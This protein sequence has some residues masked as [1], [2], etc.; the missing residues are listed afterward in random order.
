MFVWFGVQTLDTFRE[1]LSSERPEGCSFM[2]L[3]NSFKFVDSWS[4]ILLFRT[5]HFWNSTTQLI[6]YTL[7]NALNC[8]GLILTISS[9]NRQFCICFASMKICK[10]CFFHKVWCIFE[11]AQKMCRKNYPEQEIMINIAI[12][13]G[14][15]KNG[16]VYFLAFMGIPYIQK[17]QRIYL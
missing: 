8:M 11:I 12:L 10:G 3:I 14:I 2:P 15:S 5:H 9:K 1:G 7:A 17:L 4:K 16:N 6:L 13:L